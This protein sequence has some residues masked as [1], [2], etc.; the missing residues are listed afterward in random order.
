MNALRE[1]PQKP[2]HGREGG[3]PPLAVAV[4]VIVAVIVAAAGPR[5]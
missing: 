4:A 3:P 5:R 2:L 1:R